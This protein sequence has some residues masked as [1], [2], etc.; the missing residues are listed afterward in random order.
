MA[1]EGVQITGPRG[2]RFDEL[3]TP[4]P[5]TC[6]GAGREVG[7]RRA[8]L[9]VAREARQQEMSAGAKLDFLEGPGDP[10][11]PDWRVARPC[12]GLATGAWRSPARPTGNDDQRAELRGNV[13]LADFEDATAPIW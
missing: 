10:G 7:G 8:E 6:R 5:F 12:P 13:W 2:D 1:S 11:D 9:L 3:R 4:R